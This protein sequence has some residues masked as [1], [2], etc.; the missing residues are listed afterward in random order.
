MY[1]LIADD[2]P[3]IVEILTAEFKKSGAE[4]VVTHTSE[5]AIN[6]CKT[7]IFDAYI[8]DMLMPEGREGHILT[9]LANLRWVP[10]VMVMTG[11]ENISAKNVYNNNVQAFIRKPFRPVDM[12]HSIKFH[13]AERGKISIGRILTD[14]ELE[15]RLIR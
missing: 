14:R 4:I 10:L 9:Y 1:I 2:D 6:I 3:V 13:W 7:E 15:I 8:I 11:Y 5:D 12:V